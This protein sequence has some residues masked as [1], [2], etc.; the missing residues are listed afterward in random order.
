MNSL[1]Q[2][3]K[4]V[5]FALLSATRP[6]T[7][8]ANVGVTV[9]MLQIMAPPQDPDP[10]W[11]PSLASHNSL[12]RVPNKIQGHS[13]NQCARNDSNKADTNDAG[14]GD[15][16]THYDIV[17]RSVSISIFQVFATGFHCSVCR[18]SVGCGIHAVGRHL[19]KFHCNIVVKNVVR[20]HASMIS[21][22]DRL[23][24]L[25]GSNEM[26]QRRNDA[27]ARNKSNDGNTDNAYPQS[28]SISIFQVFSTGFYCSDC[29]ISVGCGIHA[30]G[31]H[32]KKSHGNIAVQNISLLHKRMSSTM[33][34]LSKS[35]QVESSV[36]RKLWDCVTCLKCT[37]CK[38]FYR[39]RFNFDRHISRS[40]G[41][42][43]GSIP[44][45]TIYM[46][47][48][49]G[50]L[51]EMENSNSSCFFLSKI[52]EINEFASVAHAVS[53]KT[54]TTLQAVQ[55][56]DH[57]NFAPLFPPD[58]FCNDDLRKDDPVQYL[59]ANESRCMYRFLSSQPKSKRR[60]RAF[61]FGAM[62]KHLIGDYT[63]IDCLDKSGKIELNIEIDGTS[64]STTVTV[65]NVSDCKELLDSIV[66][67]GKSLEE[68]GKRKEVCG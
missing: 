32:L 53:L 13:Y 43:A 58:Y 67:L 59:N 3:A 26:Q 51:V 48:E 33:D 35:I 45:K 64:E 9:P 7:A 8:S 4:S 6:I 68:K 47:A 50:R 12:S 65:M 62:Y 24:K 61:V 11:R 19:K 37:K 57:D 14:L 1:K 60:K 42:C 27:H 10:D 49:C 28:V 25:K 34:R 30:V 16:D 39:Q 41:R 20:L 40:N 54:V 56:S 29:R 46:K 5:F 44:T 18:I 55:V 38:H 23:V 63:L 22:R 31:R 15:N 52:Q 36:G 2:L 66:R 17:S 21:A